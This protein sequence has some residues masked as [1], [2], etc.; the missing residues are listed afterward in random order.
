MDR[1][2]GTPEE[3]L[4]NDRFTAVTADILQ[5]WLIS[6]ASMNNRRVACSSSQEGLFKTGDFAEFVFNTCDQFKMS[7]EA[8]YLALET[9]DRFMVQH[10][11]DLYNHVTQSES[12]HRQADWK[13]LLDR[14][15]NQLKLR[16]VSCCQIASKL[17]SHYKVV[18][19]LKARRFLR[20]CCG[21]RYTAD[22]ILQSELRVLKTLNYNVTIPSTLTYIETLLEILGHND[23]ETEVKVYH[24]VAMQVLTVVYIKYSDVYKFLFEVTALSPQ[25]KDRKKYMA[26]KADKML[27]AVSVIGSS[28]YLADQLL[29]DKIIKELSRITHIP[30]DDIIDLTSVIVQLIMEGSMYLCNMIFALTTF[31]S[32]MILANPLGDYRLQNILHT[33]NII[34]TREEAEAI[35]IESQSYGTTCDSA[36]SNSTETLPE[37]AVSLCPWY[38]ELHHQSGLFPSHVL[39]AKLR[40]DNRENRSPCKRLG[41]RDYTCV[42]IQRSVRMINETCQGRGCDFIRPIRV[43]AQCVRTQ[44]AH[45]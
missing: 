17:T 33:E 36:I 5:E 19:A 24:A 2:F 26:V 15:K 42:Y 1:I 14:I 29:S 27:L 18:S 40:C 7:P 8:K 23:H 21:H 37:Y 12:K 6:L 43:G 22:G 41:S 13:A 30:C 10:I 9:F 16:A 45:A 3:P 25:N 35:A 28:V 20:D 4:F 31:H 11:K 39:K 44:S 38:Y 32:T 34:I